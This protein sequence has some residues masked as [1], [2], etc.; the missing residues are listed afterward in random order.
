MYPLLTTF[1]VLSITGLIMLAKAASSAPEGLE[2]A[3]G[4]HACDPNDLTAALSVERPLPTESL[5]FLE[6]NVATQP[7]L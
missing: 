7:W 3:K 5:V 6:Q 2:D 1:A 4:F